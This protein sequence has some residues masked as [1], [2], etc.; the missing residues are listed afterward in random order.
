MER[1]R[2]IAF[3][4]HHCADHNPAARPTLPPPV[5]YSEYQLKQ[6][7]G[8]G[9][10]GKVYRATVR[11]SDDDV[12]IKFLRKSFHDDPDA[13]DRFRAEAA[14]VASLDHPGIVP[15]RGIGQ[16]TSG[17]WFMVMD[18]IAGRDLSRVAQERHDPPD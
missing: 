14:V 2:A 13:V 15:I 6:L 9:G 5:L 7:I 3:E 18:L 8:A 10:V 4:E 16:T 17:L 11:G 1:I 12:A